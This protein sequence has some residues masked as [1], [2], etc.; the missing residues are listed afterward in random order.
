MGCL[1][2]TKNTVKAL[3]LELCRI[4]SV[5]QEPKLGFVLQPTAPLSTYINQNQCL[6][7]AGVLIFAA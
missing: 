5:Q 1:M 4:C 6:V 3:C 2:E 7:Q